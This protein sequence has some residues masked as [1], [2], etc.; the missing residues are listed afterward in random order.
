MMHG[1]IMIRWGKSIPGR[2]A[3]SLAVFGSAINRYETLSKQGRI[4]GHRE[5]FSI[6]GRDGG[7]AL[8]EGEVDELTKILSEEDNIRL[9]N[10]ASAVVDDF[11]IQTFVGGTDQAVQELTGTYTASLRDIG[12]M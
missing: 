7:F 3:A 2:E 10:Q 5:Y 11:E 12:Y 4:N 6:T 8:I 9:N 1:A